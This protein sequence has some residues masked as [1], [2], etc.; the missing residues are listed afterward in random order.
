MV[1]IL[2]EGFTYRNDKGEC[3]ASRAFSVNIELYVHSYLPSSTLPLPLAVPDQV[4]ASVAQS[5]T[6]QP[7]EVIK[8]STCVHI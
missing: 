3:T 8:V 1:G 6:I 7:S 5:L 2:R 4:L